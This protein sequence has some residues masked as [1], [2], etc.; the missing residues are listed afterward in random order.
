MS[1]MQVIDKTIIKVYS[2]KKDSLFFGHQQL[3]FLIVLYAS[4]TLLLTGPVM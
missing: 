1:I 2:F 3:N 4:W